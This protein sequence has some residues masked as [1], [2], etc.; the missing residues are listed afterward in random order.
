MPNK[1]RMSGKLVNW[2]AGWQVETGKLANRQTKKG[3]VLFGVLIIV[4]T[5]S[6]IGAGLVALLSSLAIGNQYEINRAQALYLAEAGI[7]HAIHE[8][9]SQAIIVLSEEYFIPS[10]ALGDGT[11]DVQLEPSQFLIIA[12]GRVGGVKRAIQ[13]K[14]NPF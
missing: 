6:L 11:Y 3:A 12:T 10:T 2:L 5:I 9:K 8:L 1:N 4:L 14:Y 7:N 13:L